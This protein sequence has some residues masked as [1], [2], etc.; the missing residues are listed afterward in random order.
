METRD[1]MGMQKPPPASANTLAETE[2]PEGGGNDKNGMYMC[3]RGEMMEHV[4]AMWTGG[5]MWE[6]AAWGG[7]AGTGPAWAGAAW[8]GAQ[9][10]R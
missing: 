10:W 6:G 1:N 7:D 8:V 4:E 2:G 5:V 9:P 3:R